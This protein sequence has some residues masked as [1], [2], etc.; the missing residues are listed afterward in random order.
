M[1]QG[2]RAIELFLALGASAGLAVGCGLPYQDGAAGP[3]SGGATA[4][5]P[6]PGAGHHEGGEGGEGGEGEAGHGN[7][8]HGERK[9]PGS[10]LT[11]ATVLGLMQGHLLVA[12]E[13]M[14]RGRAADAE[15]HLAH[16][17]D[18]LYGDLEP[19]LSRRGAV[20]FRGKLTVLQD[21]I[22]TAPTAPA[23][24]Q[25]VEEARRS[26]D[27]ALAV[28][29]NWERRDPAFVATVIRELL[30]TAASEYEAAITDGRIAETV[31]YQDSRGFVL[32]A[33]QLFSGIAPQLAASDPALERKLASTFAALKPAWPDPVPPSRPVLTAQE[34]RQRTAAL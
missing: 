30:N 8:S 9:D 14:Q 32:Y 10:P 33:E 22:R 3:E 26:I 27:Q 19:E 2:R 6:A 5:S 20:P 16:P 12:G 4:T 24:A 18:E 28:L 11:Y 23:T 7:T 34:V 25:A 13:L 31:E 21:L 29:P 17:A 15:P 1:G